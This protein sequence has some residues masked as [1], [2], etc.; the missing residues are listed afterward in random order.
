MHKSMRRAVPAAAAAFL[1][2]AAPGAVLA[3]ASGLTPPKIDNSRVNPAPL[4][5]DGAQIRGEQGSVDL[6]VYVNYSGRP[7]GKLKLVKSSGF[8][9]LDNSAV[10]AVLGWHYIPAMTADGDTRSAW[11]PVHIEF[12]LPQQSA[13]PPASPPPPAAPQN[14][15]PV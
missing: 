3:Q 2:M 5:P 9:D 14:G 8:G 10:E 13:P 7:T 1:S 11:M 4:Y 6:S 15:A 12:K